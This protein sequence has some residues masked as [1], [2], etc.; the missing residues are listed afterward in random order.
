MQSCLK[1]RNGDK[2]SMPTCGPVELPLFDWFVSQRLNFQFCQVQSILD[3]WMPNVHIEENL[4]ANMNHEHQCT[5]VLPV[6]NS[7]RFFTK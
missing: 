6:D 5:R 4:E 2:T 1:G 3:N 7:M